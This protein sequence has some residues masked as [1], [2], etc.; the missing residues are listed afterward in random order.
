MIVEIEFYQGDTLLYGKSIT[1]T[2]FLRQIKEIAS[3][4]DKELDNFTALLCRR[5]GWTI[6]ESKLDPVYVYD[7]DTQKAYRP[8]R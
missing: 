2:E 8:R 5:Y 4:Y 3:D 1:Y 6:T 7:R